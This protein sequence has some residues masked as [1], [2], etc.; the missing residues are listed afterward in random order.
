MTRRHGWKVVYALA[1]LAA[2][3]PLPRPAIERWYSQALYP[4]LQR[5]LTGLSN[6][7]PISLFDAMC[8]TLVAA[9]A[10]LVRRA[11]QKPRW[12]GVAYLLRSVGR[13]AAAMYLVFLATSQSSSIIR[14]SLS[15][16]LLP[17]RI[18]CITFS[19]VVDSID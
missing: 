15:T 19:Y 5:G 10:V 6:L 9:F 14:S 18:S 12:I 13:C 2:L 3:A 11:W 4:P 7:V 16:S 17:M 1:L 8:L